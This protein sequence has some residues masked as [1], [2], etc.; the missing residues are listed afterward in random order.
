[1]IKESKGTFP[2]YTFGNLSICTGITHFISSGERNI[3]FLNSDTPELILSNRL[4]L[5]ECVGFDLN[6]M[7]VGNQVHG[8][9]I[10]V[11]GKG[12]AGRGASDNQSRLPNTDALVTDVENICL[13]VMTA[14]CVP[15]LL[16]DPIRKVVAAIH[17]GWRG[18]IGGIVERTVRLMCEH[19]GCMA[20]DILAGIGPCIGACCFEV[21]EEVAA[22]FEPHY[23]EVIYTGKQPGKYQIDLGQA[24]R[25][26]L[27]NAGLNAGHVE[28]A[29]LCTV[30]HPREFSSYRYDGEAAGRFGTGIMLRSV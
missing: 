12:D 6:K 18:T 14:D 16:F 9:T 22:A 7:V 25:T 17:A 8:I 13:M 23:K 26:Q 11:V 4:Q 27:L 24:N 2:F 28:L 19:Y 15:V 21:G 30:C 1:M 20:A 5:A 3:S 10:T 29:G